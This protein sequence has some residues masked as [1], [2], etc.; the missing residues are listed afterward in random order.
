M[1]EEHVNVSLIKRLDLGNMAATAGLF[2]QDV[3]FHFFNPLLPEVQGDYVGLSGIRSFFETIGAITG[4]TFSVEPIS[5]TAVGDE[6]VVTHTKNRMTL[7]GRLIATD[8]V[9]VWRIVDGRIAEV[10]D[11]PSVH[12]PAT[13]SA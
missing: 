11:I 9:V 6:L 8:V 12:K 10:W 13:Q 4:G 2:A 1:G 7:Q 5:I 3:V